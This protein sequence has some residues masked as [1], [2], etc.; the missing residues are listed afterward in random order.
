MGEVMSFL[1]GDEGNKGAWQRALKA[2]VHPLAPG[3]GGPAGAKFEP[4]SWEPHKR[5]ESLKRLTEKY[6]LQTSLSLNPPSSAN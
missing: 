1:W 5:K 6:G 2:T 4:Q 3:G